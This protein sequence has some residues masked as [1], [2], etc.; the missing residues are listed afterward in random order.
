MLICQYQLPNND[1]YTFG[2][3]Y[4]PFRTQKALWR[5]KNWSNTDFWAEKGVLWIWL[6]EYSEAHL[7]LVG[8][9]VCLFC[10]TLNKTKTLLNKTWS[11]PNSQ[12]NWARNSGLAKAVQQSFFKSDMKQAKFS[13]WR[14]RLIYPENL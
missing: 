11:V 1:W 5:P 12:E 9:F 7:Y 8:G 14:K 6:V 13:S 2:S 4:V 10:V 3:Q